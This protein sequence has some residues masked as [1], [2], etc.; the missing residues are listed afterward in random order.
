MI[1]P[2][3]FVLVEAVKNAQAFGLEFRSTDG[4]VSGISLNPSGQIYLTGHL[5]WSS[6]FRR[7]ERLVRLHDRDHPRARARRA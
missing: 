3:E 2:I 1:G 6:D 4:L 5:V 7:D